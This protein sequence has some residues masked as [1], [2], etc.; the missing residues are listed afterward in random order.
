MLQDEDQKQSTYRMKIEGR[1]LRFTD[2]R[3]EDM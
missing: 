3:R 1:V 2:N